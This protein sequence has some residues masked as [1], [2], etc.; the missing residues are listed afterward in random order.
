MT[1]PARPPGHDYGYEAHAAAVER[2]NALDGMEDM[3]GGEDPGLEPAPTEPFCGCTDCI[4]RETLVAAWPIIEAGIRSGDFD[5]PGTTS[6]ESK[7]AAVIE[8]CKDANMWA[9]MQP[10]EVRAAAE[11]LSV[12]EMQTRWEAEDEG[13]ES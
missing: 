4:V 10:L 11:G 1:T 13:T 5:E 9:D 7:L 6:A 8:L 3:E 2:L 12:E